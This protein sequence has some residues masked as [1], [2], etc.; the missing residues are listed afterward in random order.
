MYVMQ[1]GPLKAEPTNNFRR[2]TKALSETEP[3]YDLNNRTAL[4]RK[5][6][7]LTRLDL[8]ENRVGIQ[9]ARQR[10]YEC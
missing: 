3:N 10:R 2:A 7:S 1:V 5:Y 8:F 4:S 9:C 6:E